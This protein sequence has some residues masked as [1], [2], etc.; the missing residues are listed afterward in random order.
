MLECFLLCSFLSN[1]SVLSIATRTATPG[2]EGGREG[3]SERARG[4]ERKW[5]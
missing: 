1:T 4:R 5:V 3:A 2:R